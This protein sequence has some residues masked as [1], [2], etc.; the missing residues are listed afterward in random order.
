MLGGQ[1]CHVGIKHV[2][3][4]IY[5]DN[6]I[7]NNSNNCNDN[8]NDNYVSFSLVTWAIAICQFF[9]AKKKPATREK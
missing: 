9:E 6:N 2:Y 5:I 4:Y 8:D 1:Q 7:D 3:I